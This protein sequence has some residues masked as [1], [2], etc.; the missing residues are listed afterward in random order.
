MGPRGPVCYC[1]FLIFV[2]L[3]QVILKA[4]PS[5]PPQ[6]SGPS[7][8]SQQRSVV[9]HEAKRFEMDYVGKGGGKRIKNEPGALNYLKLRNQE[10]KLV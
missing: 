9:G 3:A 1:L 4:P 2:C 5:Y 8:L 6:R 7:Y 10:M